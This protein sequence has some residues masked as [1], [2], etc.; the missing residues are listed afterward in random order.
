MLAQKASKPLDSVLLHWK[1]NQKE[2]TSLPGSKLLKCLMKEHARFKEMKKAEYSTLSQQFREALIETTVDK[3]M[4]ID[5]AVESKS[6]VLRDAW[7]REIEKFNDAI[8]AKRR[9]ARPAP[10]EQPVP[11]DTFV[12]RLI[13]SLKKHPREKASAAHP[14]GKR[15]RSEAPTVTLA[16]DSDSDSVITG[17]SESDEEDEVLAGKQAKAAVA[18]AYKKPLEITARAERYV[19]T[20]NPSP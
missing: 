2:I 14:G 5:Y 9:S 10:T 13:A 7:L 4:Q 17:P 15:E 20:T 3:D 19:S 1:R 8:R 18:D 16:T 11:K 6:K 12:G